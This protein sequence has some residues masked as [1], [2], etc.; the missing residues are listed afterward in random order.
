MT[1]GL[2]IDECEYFDNLK[3]LIDEMM[4]EET[5]SRSLTGH[6]Y[7][8][9]HEAQYKAWFYDSSPYSIKRLHWCRYD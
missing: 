7:A 8:R 3:V 4:N 5:R 1:G 2:K 6:K 9:L